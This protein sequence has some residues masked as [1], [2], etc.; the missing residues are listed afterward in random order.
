MVIQSLAVFV[1]Y[2]QITCL[3]T[4]LR[5]VQRRLCKI[6]VFSGSPSTTLVVIS[7]GYSRTYLVSVV[8][9][10]VLVSVLVSAALASSRAALCLHSSFVT[11]SLIEV[12][13]SFHRT[14]LR[15]LR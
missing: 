1:G 6:Y 9:R 4:F 8:A 10:M 5:W 7:H 13:P 12:L 14:F 11:C 2:N 15:T 3:A